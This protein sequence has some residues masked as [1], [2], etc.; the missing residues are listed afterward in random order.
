MKELDALKLEN[1]RLRALAMQDSL[2]GLWNRGT[3]EGKV[4]E[5]LK[6]Q[7]PGVFLMMDVDE[8]KYIN[9]TYGHLTGDRILKELAGILGFYFFKKDIIGRIGGDEFAVF[10]P[11]EYSQ[12][13]VENKVE[14]LNSRFVQIGKAQGIGSRMRITV[15]AAFVQPEDD[16][17]SLY[18]RADAAMRAGKREWDKC[19]YFYD[20][21][22]SIQEEGKTKGAGTNVSPSDMKYITRQLREDQLESGAW[23]QDYDTFLAVYRF[24]E[25]GLERTGLR[26]HLIL[27]SLTDQQG[28]FV[29]LEGREELVEKLRESICASLRFSD[30]YTRYSS[31]QFL[32]MAMGAAQENM[33]IITARIQNAFRARVPDRADIMLT[34]SF[35]PLKA[36]ERRRHGSK[37]KEL[38]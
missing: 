5:I 37:G 13:M 35:Y 33:E 25:R 9:D 14:S 27:V 26:V 21:S 12:E 24:T 10:L 31:C 18:E 38:A 2:T 16:F 36:L 28:A 6:Q 11:G 15:G 30:I 4:N 20:P 22:M 17:V 34:F 19:L 3:I 23:C 7:V 29:P 32:A 1:D 8:F